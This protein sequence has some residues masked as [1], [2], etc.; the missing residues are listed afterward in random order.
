MFGY[1]V[2]NPKALAEDRQQRFR[3]MY[4]GLCRTLRKRHGLV[5]SAALSYDLTF[6]ALLLNAVYEPGE[7]TLMERCLA[8][9]TRQHAYVS[10]PVLDY[11]ADMNVALAYHK[12]RDNW[13]DDKNLLAAGGSA[14]LLKAYRN[15]EK[16]WPRRCA[17]IEKWIDQI[18]R[19]EQENALEIDP[20]VNATGK[21][22]G[23]LF[24]WPGQ[25]Q[26]AEDLQTVG[27]GLGRFVYFMDAYDDLPR[28]LRRGSYNP[29]KPLRDREDF[30]QMCK[31]AL[32]MMAADAADAFE[33]LPVVTDADILRNVLYSGVW[34][35]YAVLQG[36]RNAQ[37][38]GA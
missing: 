23:E 34:T 9:P 12:L 24:V 1:I 36:K 4:C 35:R 6:L 10:T 37:E 19:L 5:T 18:R 32:M 29:L 8:H 25:A 33:R 14:L 30:E 20:P 26:W 22:L 2:V 27:D 17:A 15:V 11:A 28:D 31:T 21:L 3:A 16:A 38:K 7:Q 13:C